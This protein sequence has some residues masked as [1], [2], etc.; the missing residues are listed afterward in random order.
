M[1]CA[2][3]AAFVLAATGCS[4]G[5]A[6][7]ERYT[8]SYE[9]ADALLAGNDLPVFVVGNPFDVPPADFHRS[10]V[11][12]LQARSDE[13]SVHFSE[14]LQDGASPFR[15]IIVFAPRPQISAA[16]LCNNPG[17][18]QAATVSPG[19]QEVPILAS[20][21]RNGQLLSQADG[22]IGAGDGPTGRRFRAGLGQIALALFPGEDPSL[23]F[24]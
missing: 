6:L 8:T 24:Q 11:S 19:A 14:R 20:F 3:I 7:D 2:A 16:Q 1:S 12:A 17:A 13:V 5:A 21:C 22:V 15:L 10:V 18:L 23:R 9:P 4:D